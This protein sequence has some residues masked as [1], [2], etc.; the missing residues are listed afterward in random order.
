MPNNSLNFLILAFA[1]EKATISLL[2]KI[3]AQRPNAKI[4]V[5]VD[6]PRPE[7]ATNIQIGHASLVASLSRMLESGEEFDL[8]VR[9]SNLGTSRNLIDA[10]EKLKG[11]CE[12]FV[13]LEDDCD[14]HPDFFDFSASAIQ[15][16]VLERG[17]PVMFSGANHLF[18][19][20]SLMK[21][22]AISTSLSHVW[23]WGSSGEA[24]G[25]LVEFL[26][27]GPS[28][29]GVEKIQE[30]IKD[31]ISYEI[32]RSHWT[33]MLSSDWDELSWDYR[34]QFWLWANGYECLIPG[35]NLVMNIGFDSVA[36]NSSEIPDHYQNRFISKYEMS[37]RL[38]L[39]RKF[40]V[41]WELTGYRT[42]ALVR[43]T[44]IWLRERGFIR[45]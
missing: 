21:T 44:R 23:G 5:V 19:P 3:L 40:L 4:V 14:P 39:N 34:L 24:L 13:V 35:A 36:M 7:A 17:S 42:F 25:E 32:Y 15:S 11:N 37:K 20:L 2:R 41:W 43:M 16:L 45:K 10:L 9:P 30:F 6:V 12:G 31:T 38:H 22:A 1:R 8:L 27:F 33:R 18:P 28:T 29:A 26:K